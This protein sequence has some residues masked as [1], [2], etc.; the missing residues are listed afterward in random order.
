MNHRKLLLPFLL[1]SLAGCSS[2]ASGL[3][4]A[5]EGG[6][7]SSDAAELTV[8]AMAL[9]SDTEVTV[10]TASISDYPELENARSEVVRLEPEGTVLE[11][12]A[13]VVVRADLIDAAPGARVTIHQL[14]DIDGVRAW[15]AV[16][17]VYDSETG[18]AEAYVTTFAPL[19][20]VVE[21]VGATATV[22]GTLTWSSGDPADGAP[23][24]LRDGD[25]VVHSTSTDAT[26]AFT[27][28]DVE[29]GSYTV[30]VMYECTVDEAI[31]LDAGE[32]EDLALTLCGG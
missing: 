9:A 8:P 3:I 5:A 31:V 28:T 30:H 4:T 20:V 21:E 29:P 6:V 13:T 24:E 15:R 25:T 16:E 1:L 22:R 11:T 23:V 19:G 12:P 26:G 7:V 10:E 32:T 14:R 2:S 18:D 27:F 17:S